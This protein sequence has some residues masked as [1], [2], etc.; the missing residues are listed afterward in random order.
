MLNSIP[1]ISK[2][3]KIIG[4]SILLLSVL[5][6]FQTTREYIG[7]L[8]VFFFIFLLLTILPF[9][10]FYLYIIYI[11][12]KNQS[13]RILTTIL[14]LLAIIGIVAFAQ[15]YAFGMDVADG[16][17]KYSDI[18]KFLSP[19]KIAGLFVYGFVPPILTILL[20]RKLKL[21]KEIPIETKNYERFRLTIK[22]LVLILIS[23]FF[24]LTIFP[25]IDMLSVAFTQY[26][27]GN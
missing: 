15:E 20:W 18:D 9:V 22:Y 4:A 23:A 6:Y 11:A 26:I 8:F 1:N 24:L 25:A 16:I 7:I 12:I 19:I 27:L 21:R 10:F 3:Y 2:K 13:Y 17:E 5:L 14:V